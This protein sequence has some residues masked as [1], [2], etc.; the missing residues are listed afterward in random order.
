MNPDKIEKR[1]RVDYLNNAYNIVLKEIVDDEINLR[2]L[3]RTNPDLVVAERE[4]K[5]NSDGAVVKVG[6]S[7]GVFMAD[8]RAKYENRKKRLDAIE[9]LIKEKEVK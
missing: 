7:A 3:E 8:V 6:V 4:E 1:A 2:V 5:R 9:S